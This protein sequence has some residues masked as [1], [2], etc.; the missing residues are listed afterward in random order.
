MFPSTQAVELGGHPI[1]TERDICAL[2]IEP[3]LTAGQSPVM[4]GEGLTPDTAVA[5]SLLGSDSL[6]G[7]LWIFVLTQELI[8]GPFLC[9]VPRDPLQSNQRG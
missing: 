9:F 5:C 2:V 4:G 7:P 6:P 1:P 3:D 8:E